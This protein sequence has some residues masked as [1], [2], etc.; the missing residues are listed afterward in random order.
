MQRPAPH[1]TGSVSLTRGFR[2]SVS[3]RFEPDHSDPAEPRF[4]FSYRIRIRN[5][6]DIR[7]QLLS[8]DWKITDGRGVTHLVR[9]DGVVGHQPDLSPGQGFEYSSFCPLPTDWGTMEGA[10]TMET[11]NPDGSRGERFQI[12]VG[13]FYLMT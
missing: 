12:E 4:V 5:E 8:R 6:S 3:P 11:V 10:Y 1:T 2:V 13:R 7:A 9:G